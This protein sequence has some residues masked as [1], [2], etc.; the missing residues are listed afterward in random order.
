MIELGADRLVI[1]GIFAL[2]VVVAI[3]SIAIRDRYTELRRGLEAPSDEPALVGPALAREE[4]GSVDPA[5]LAK[6]DGSRA[7]FGWPSLR[8]THRV[9]LP[10]DGKQRSPTSGRGDRKAPGC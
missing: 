1:L 3:A 5:V 4:P 9:L 7:R 8:G 2:I 6:H 10:P